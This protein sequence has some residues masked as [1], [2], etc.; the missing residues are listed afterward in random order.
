MKA[1]KEQVL[2]ALAALRKGELSFD[3]FRARIN[4]LVNEGILADFQPYQ[5]SRVSDF[6][7]CFDCYDPKAPPARS[8]RKRWKMTSKRLNGEPGYPKEQIIEEALALEQCLL[9]NETRWQR[10][11]RFFSVR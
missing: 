5:R 2:E 10:I 11:R 7:W 4:E 3:E 6:I 1:S 8:L 9:G